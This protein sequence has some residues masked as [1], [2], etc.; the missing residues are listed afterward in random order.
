MKAR[1]F[2]IVLFCVSI[3]NAQTKSVVY[4]FD[5]AIDSQECMNCDIDSE[6][7]LLYS[8]QTKDLELKGV[9]D[10]SYSIKNIAYETIAVPSK[11]LQKVF[12]EASNLEVNFGKTGVDN[13]LSVYVNPFVRING[14]VKMIKSI[15][16]EVSYQSFQLSQNRAATFASES[17]LKSGVWYKFSA[18]KT[19]VYKLTKSVL[20][21]AGI[22]T[23]SLNPQH[24]N[25]YANQMP[26]LPT[27]NFDYHPDDLVKNP[28]FIQ[29]ESDGSF[30]D[31]DYVLCFVNG[32]DDE[33]LD[34]GV[35]FNLSEN[36]NDSLTYFYL[37]VNSGTSPKRIQSIANSTDAVTHSVTSFNAAVLHEVNTVNLISSGTNWLGESFDVELSHSFSMELPGLVASQPVKMKTSAA[38]K[39]Q[40]GTSY[41]NVRV[42]GNLVDKLTSFT[43]NNSYSK[44]TNIVSDTVFNTSTSQLNY[45]IDFSRTSPSTLGWLN[46]IVLNYR[47]STSMSSGQFLCRDWNSVGTNNVSSFSVS[48]ANSS[49]LVWDVTNPRDAKRINGNLSGSNLSFNQSTDT[50]RS[51]AVFNSSQAYTPVFFKSIANQNLHALPQVDYIIVS[52]ST[53]LS[54]ANRLADL[55]RNKGLSV[56]VVEIQ[57][58]YNEFSCGVADPVAIR[59]FTKMFYDRAITNPV[60]APQSLLLFGDGSYDALNR[61]A[62][63]TALLPTYRSVD[64]ED[65]NT[66]LSFTSSF[67]SDDFFGMLDDLESMDKFDLMDVGVGRFPVNTLEEATQI[68]NKVEH[69]MN[70]GS[71]LFSDVSCNSDGSN[72]TFGD[73]RGKSLLI[74]DDQNGGQF[75]YDCEALSDLVEGE[76]NEMNVLKLYLDAYQQVVTSGGQRYPDV[77]NALNQYIAQGMLTVNYVGHGGETGL[78][79]ERIVTIPM[80]E[81]WKNIDRL[82]L[83]ISATCEFSRFDDPHRTSAGEIMLMTPNGGAVAL[84]TTT[85]LVYIS[86]NSALVKHLYKN[87]FDEVNGKPLSMGEIIRL[88]KNLSAGDNNMRNFTLLGD[89]AL[90]LGKPRPNIKTDDI[91]GNLITTAIDTMKALSKITITG[92]IEDYLGNELSNYNGVVSPTV[93]DKYKIKTTLGQDSDSPVT[94]FDIQNNI[95]YKGKSTVKNGKFEFTFIVPKDINYEYGKSKVSYY[96][97]NGVG[98]KLGFDTSV[99]IGGVDPNGLDDDIG[100]G[101]HLFMNDEN[102]ANG[103]LTDVNPLFIANI[104]DENGIN[105]SGN[106]IGHDITAIIDENTANPIIMNNYYEADLDTYKSGKV[107]FQF[108]NLEEGRHTLKFKVWDVN[109]NSSEEEMEFIVR[110]KEDIAIS[111]LLNYPNPFTTHTEFYFEHNQIHNITEAKIEI[112]TVTGKLVRTIY[113]NVESCAYR[114]EGIPWDGLDEY[115]DKLARGVYVYRLSIKNSEGKTDQKLEK[116]YIL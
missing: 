23:G 99:V 1:I 96:A 84:L 34:G 94:D 39:N 73:W 70:Y 67:T 95:I 35:G 81:E 8:T 46:R 87:L 38:S 15:E 80:I 62:N 31:N 93:Y 33:S 102:F 89:P 100:P 106:G 98:D 12:T 72:S 2:I 50:L 113:S 9:Y 107:Q 86:T 78:S 77:E 18:N 69:Y 60:T 22:N 52:H 92:H 30:D 75:V 55:H 66:L 56:H 114:S 115:G 65:N 5:L 116:L 109:N 40:L 105:T 7:K 42:N 108:V 11:L 97:Q 25:I 59:W 61:E 27:Y 20:E 63:N 83:F 90:L 51:F 54:Q 104:N 53:F 48:N 4:N 110:N 64:S 36:N 37:E 6:S 19:G 101:I 49:T 91:N 57:Q 74:A 24:I 85:R 47:R 43:N 13:Y 28:I 10:L 58:V 3:V 112:M 16:L 82:P 32:P 111:H 21:S 29:G 79:L 88:T 45:L 44:G 41:F 17:V 14:V 26:V 71:N 68:V 76:H 103:G